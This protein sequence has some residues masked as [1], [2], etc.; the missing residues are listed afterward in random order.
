MTN[1]D[2]IDNL[3][4]TLNDIQEGD[5]NERKR[6][7]IEDY[8]EMCDPISKDI[9]DS[10]IIISIE[11]Q[12]EMVFVSINSGRYG[13]CRQNWKILKNI[14]VYE[15]IELIDTE[16]DLELVIQNES[17]THFEKI[18]LTDHDTVNQ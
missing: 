1:N 8:L 18:R 10:L 7:I 3:N 5:G 16:D 14:Q 11:N 17:K 12:I 2:K 15:M 13:H 4:C 6:F 9:G